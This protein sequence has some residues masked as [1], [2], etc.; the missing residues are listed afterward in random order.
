[1]VEYPTAGWDQEKLKEALKGSDVMMKLGAIRVL[2]ENPKEEHVRPLIEALNDQ[3]R[4]VRINAAIALGKI[5]NPLAVIALLYHIVSDEDKDVQLYSLW[6]YRQIDFAK[7]SPRLVKVLM[8]STNEDMIRFAANE[9]RQKS[10]YKAVESLIQN[11]ESKQFYTWYDL[12]IKTVNALYTIGYMTVEQ[13]VKCLDSDDLRVSIN[14]IYT[15]G[16]IGDERSVQPLISHIQSG[17]IEVR[18]RISD[19]LI[20]IG[21]ASVPGLIKLLED[22]DR[23]IKWIAAYTLGKLGPEAESALINALNEKGPQASE[24]VIY[25]LGIAGGVTSFD[26]LY[27]IYNVSMDESVKAWSLISLANIVARDYQHLKGHKGINSFLDTLGEQLK[28]H[29]LLN[30]NTLYS[31]G[32]IYVS[33]A[34][35]PSNIEDFMTNVET[36]VKCF[37]LSLIEKDNIIAKTYR[38]LYGSYLKLMTSKSPEIMDYIDKDINDFK[39]EAEKAANKKEIIF[40]LGRVLAQLRTAYEDKNYK[41]VNKFA[42]YVD[43]CLT[44]EEFLAEEAE[45]METAKRTSQKEL[46]TLHKDIEIIQRKLNTLLASF[47]AG[48]DGDS[49]AQIYR[50][51]TELAKMDTGMYEDYRIVESCLKNIVSRTKLPEDIK[52]DLYYKILM[53]GK[54]GITQVELVV[55]Q[56]LKELGVQKPEAAEAVVMPGEGAE[57]TGEKKS[58]ALE[59]IAIVVLLILIAIV[60][61]LALNKF[62]Y[63]KLP[64]TFPIEWLNPALMH[65][66]LLN[67]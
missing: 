7:A 24:D 17:N 61:I 31:L 29:M 59:Y 48:E 52:S 44:M 36:S 21:R 4:L 60:V 37:D 9:I 16:K 23:E 51:S 49:S 54:N 33:R 2:Q 34:L 1:M 18:S 11:F 53:I 64:Y 50:L 45:I 14:A 43:L 58:K 25:A 57:A 67:Q 66:M 6:A 32:K 8:E 26:V 42:E 27:N 3:E 63:I 15:L 39:K 56:I 30:Y 65:E 47:G 40:L 22:K 35:S 10:D 5:K 41:F 20:K 12:D 13:L 55:D 28:P 62:G 46:T 38:L 19:A